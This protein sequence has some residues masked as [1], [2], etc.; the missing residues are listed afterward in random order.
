MEHAYRL[1]TGHG[2]GPWEYY[3]DIRSWIFPGAIAGIMKLAWWIDLSTAQT[4]VAIRF[5]MAVL[6]L[7]I[8][9]CTFFWG[10]RSVFKARSCLPAAGGNLA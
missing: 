6:S 4:L 3:Y 10:R 1:L 7:P 9:V 2:F 5:T 8:I